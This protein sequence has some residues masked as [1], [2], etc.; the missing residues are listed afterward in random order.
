SSR[1]TTGS[2]SIRRERP[3]KHGSIRAG[4]RSARIAAVAAGAAGRGEVERLLAA[5]ARNG[6]HRELLLEIDAFAR[7]ARRRLARTR[8]ELE[9]AAAVTA[10]VFKKRHAV[11]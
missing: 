7:R 11:F 3:G 2:R 5:P 9:A 8:Q 10:F 6:E 1:P 4:P